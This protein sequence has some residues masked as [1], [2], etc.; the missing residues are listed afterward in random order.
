MVFPDVFYWIRVGAQI[1]YPGFYR[2]S[3]DLGEGWGWGTSY[4]AKSR[5]AS[6]APKWP[7]KEVKNVFGL[8]PAEP[9]FYPVLLPPTPPLDFTE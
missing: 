1:R 2:I 8:S 9:P 7:K 3:R 6:K 5:G 4:S